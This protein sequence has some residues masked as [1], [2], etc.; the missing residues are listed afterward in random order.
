MK[1]R[2]MTLAVLFGRSAVSSAALAGDQMKETT[3]SP[4]ATSDKDA[5]MAMWTKSKDELEEALGTGKDKAFY[6]QVLENMGYA[7]TSVNADDPD[8][9]EYEIVKG[10]ESYE[11]QIDFDNGLADAAGATQ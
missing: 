3:S 10:G 5:R 7:I 9:L 8:Y 11:V 2:S 4:Q 6:R 1:T